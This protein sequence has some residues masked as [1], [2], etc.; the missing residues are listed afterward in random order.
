MNYNYFQR[1]CLKRLANP[2]EKASH[3][4][5]SPME[6]IQEH[7][8]LVAETLL[9]LFEVSMMC[10]RLKRQIFYGKVKRLDPMPDIDK[11]MDLLVEPNQADL[12]HSVLG[13]VSEIHEIYNFEN[14]DE[15]CGDY[16]FYS[17]VIHHILAKMAAV[18]P[19]TVL[20]NND[21]KLAKRYSSKFTAEEANKRA[22]KEED[23]WI[24]SCRRAK[25]FFST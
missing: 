22:D 23:I 4:N 5:L 3:D 7:K 13:A 1:Q 19:A 14:V 12:L 10:D 18:A 8:D 6:R 24:E 11:V 2:T 9:K 16:M 15:E 17:S 25:R 20:E 21:K